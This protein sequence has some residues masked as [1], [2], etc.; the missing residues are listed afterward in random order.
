VALCKAASIRLDT[1]VVEIALVVV[2][3]LDGP[4]Q[5]SSPA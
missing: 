5:F 1:A 3:G 2:A 4:P